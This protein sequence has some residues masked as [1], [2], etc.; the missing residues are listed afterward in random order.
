MATSTPER[1]SRA[2]ITAAVSRLELPSTYVASAIASAASANATA[3]FTEFNDSTA[4]AVL[5]SGASSDVRSTTSDGPASAGQASGT[6][7]S[8]GAAL[9]SLSARRAWQRD[10]VGNEA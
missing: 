6:G 1:A 10:G 3:A 2:A 8:S 7:A 4:A 5:T 9:H